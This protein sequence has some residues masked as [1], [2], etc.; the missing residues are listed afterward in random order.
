M[1]FPRGGKTLEKLNIILSSSL[2]AKDL[3]ANILTFSR[4][5]E[6]SLKPIQIHLVIKEVVKMIRASIPANIRM[7]QDIKNV[8][9][10]VLA[11]ATQIYQVVMNL[12]TNAYHAISSEDGKIIVSQREID[13]DEKNL[14]PEFE[15]DAGRYVLIRVSDTGCG[16][17]K[18]LLNKI[19]DPYFT[20]KKLGDGTGLGLSVV[21]GIVKKHRGQISVYSEVGQG[22]VFNVFLPSFENPDGVSVQGIDESRPML[23]GD[24]HI[25]V[26]DDETLD[27][28]D[29]LRN[30][31]KLRIPGC[32]F[33]PQR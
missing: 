5:S 12:C 1:R 16:M 33:Y 8:E 30:A 27:R 32:W 6:Q 17:E 3:V 18:S 26:V 20:T 15:C 13:L 29:D 24:E 22:T 7:V 10:L 28:E 11:D 9:A 25:V 14:L 2:R 19:F 31:G 21:H 4:E 23:H